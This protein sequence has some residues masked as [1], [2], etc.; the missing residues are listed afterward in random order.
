MATP[1]I[2]SSKLNEHP[3]KSTVASNR[4]ERNGAPA[5]L[6]QNT[7]RRDS[8]PITPASPIGSSSNFSG[9]KRPELLKEVRWGSSTKVGELL[10]QKEDRHWLNSESGETALIDTLNE[11]L[12]VLK[13]K[14]NTIKPENLDLYRI[15]V[16]RL[17]Q[18][19]A[20]VNEL[21]RGKRTPLLLVASEK[22]ESTQNWV[23]GISD[24]LGKHGANIQIRDHDGR[25]PL[26]CAVTY[27]NV[28]L[29]RLLLEKGANV[30]DADDNGRTPLMCAATNGNVDLAKL[31]LHYNADVHVCNN[32]RRTALHFAA[33]NNCVNVAKLLLDHEASPSAISDGGWT[34]LHNAA[35]NGHVPIVQL[36]LE[37]RSKGDTKYEVKANSQLY[38]GMTP[39]HWAAFNGSTE[40]VQALLKVEP[41]IN[42]S[43]KD[44]F[45]RT[46]MLCAVEKKNKDLAKILSPAHAAERL[47]NEARK[48]C[49]E[50]Q[51]TVVDFKPSSKKQ[52]KQQVYKHSVYELLYAWDDG[53]K[54]P[55]VTTLGENAKSKLEFRWIHLPANNVSNS[56]YPF[57]ASN[58]ILT[59]CYRLLG[60]RC[61]SWQYYVS[62]FL[63][64]TSKQALLAKRYEE[65]GYEE[66]EAFKALE[67][68]FDQE[69]RGRFPHSHFMRPY[70]HRIITSQ[71]EGSGNK[72]D[73]KED[74]KANNTRGGKRDENEDSKTNGTT[75]KKPGGN[76]DGKMVLFVGQI[77]SQIQHFTKIVDAISSL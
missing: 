23:I 30:E 21:D 10:N 11:A 50:F 38:N 63:L 62:T 60:L 48:A 43:V 36:L 28:G 70:C 18:E 34:P 46:P 49:S 42:I 35:Q 41:A 56:L 61:V 12:F 51:A 53:S 6:V 65:G 32:R 3:R 47:S 27:G 24:L 40:V 66:L 64:L 19:G 2:T 45:G 52:Q 54:K 57:S 5:I 73:D 31:L 1:S 75:C 72:V 9:K 22:A 8:Q 20:K 59:S 25:T 74:E 69:H 7:N 71:P 4:A 15:I 58:R 26:V 67:K 55:R 17:L 37:Y 68:C 29:A 77:L 39:L 76:V 14:N 13:I 44:S 33:V 16:E